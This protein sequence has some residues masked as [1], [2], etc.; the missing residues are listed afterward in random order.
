[1]LQ[2]IFVS[3]VLLAA[4]VLS[5][6]CPIV[7]TAGEK[8]A[9]FCYF[10]SD[11]VSYVDSTETAKLNELVSLRLAAFSDVA[12]VDRAHIEKTL[13]EFEFSAF[14]L[15]DSTTSL[16]LGHW[17][18]ADLL[19][20]G[21]VS[22][23][24]RSPPQLLVEVID[25]AHADVLT[26]FET[27]LPADSK[28]NLKLT[29]A[30]VEKI[31][32]ECDEILR[33]ALPIPAARSGRVL[34]APLY[35]RNAQSTGRLDFLETDLRRKFRARNDEQP[36]CHFL[37]FPHARDALEEAT[38]IAGGLV[39]A[40]RTQWNNV[41]DCYVWGTYR[42]VDADGV[43]FPKVT[44]E[45]ELSLW[46]GRSPVQKLIDRAPVK[47]LDQLLDRLVA[48]VDGRAVAR[49]RDRR[50][51]VKQPGPA[52]DDLRKKISEDLRLRA[53]DLQEWVLQDE[54]GKT[55]PE[56]LRKWRQCV[57]LLAV[58][59][60][61]D[62][63]NE[64]AV[65][66]LLLETSRSDV[67]S[68]TNLR[69]AEFWRAW[70]GSDGWKTYCQQFGFEYEHAHL[71]KLKHRFGL[72]DN[73]AS[74]GAV[75]MYLASVER[76]LN[77]T[78]RKEDLPSDTPP[79]VI[80][81]WQNSLSREYVDRLKFVC[82]EHP[83]LLQKRANLILGRVHDVV[84]INALRAEG[85]EILWP[86]L[87]KDEQFQIEHLQWHIERTFAAIGKPERAATLIADARKAGRT[88]GITVKSAAPFVP[89]Q[90]T[91]IP[92]APAMA[93]IVR[94]APRKI[95]LERYFFVNRVT[96]L[97]LAKNRHWIGVAGQFNSGDQ[98]NALFTC[99]GGGGDM[100][101]FA[102]VGTSPVTAMLQYGD[103]L[104]LAQ[105]GDGVSQI[106]LKTSEVKAFSARDGLPSHKIQALARCGERLYAGG[107]EAQRG[108]L[109]SFDLTRQ[110]WTEHALPNVARN[111]R[112]RSASSVAL[113][114]CDVDR[115]AVFTNNY[116]ID[117]Q[118]L[119]RRHGAEAWVD[120]GERL[121]V[122]HPHFSHFSN[123]WRP[124]VHG[125]DFYAG[126]LWIAASRGL[127]AFDPERSEFS[128]AAPMA[129]EITA[130]LLD[131]DRLF[132]GALPFTAQGGEYRG[133]AVLVFDLKQRR[134]LAQIEA[135]ELNHVTAMTLAGNT[136]WLG[137]KNHSSAP[138]YA[139]EL[140]QPIAR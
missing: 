84:R 108:A 44:V 97:A 28:W 20:K 62:P 57:Q 93:P 56:W 47:E 50:A 95:S 69:A 1:M 125:L 124:K 102:Q 25:V 46:D 63:M 81:Q 130:T 22:R 79:E 109:G 77:L 4:S 101:R 120:V 52:A 76:V 26:S 126:Q 14:G 107:G 10:A 3:Q 60:F 65:R 110:T 122:R 118:I 74:F 140:E 72:A 114:A 11:G 8:P 38:L 131:G 113:L 68:L 75:W 132:C 138:V 94:L 78:Q 29:D 32:R 87:L 39:A 2:R 59:A 139:I 83:T 106:N 15:P 137:H 58:A 42:E 89:P 116:G 9:A 100:R 66:E 99:L 115:L 121:R 45:V 119:V 40:D 111:G 13:K 5:I 73:R 55:P 19:I 34:I 31:G 112:S 41:S 82:A 24:R 30:A 129:W 36:R 85:F 80:K 134:W 135:P 37:Q 27:A 71:P 16:K 61:F 105:D 136:L 64:A 88:T 98:G 23:G 90:E 33:Q 117:T 92:T 6:P 54:D 43:E 21:S 67:R 133:A 128:Y 103:Q 70:R 51:V 91:P 49:Q 127:V 18:K 12:W 86:L 123:D 7:V 35:F 17:L 48:A 53:A 96:A 104:W